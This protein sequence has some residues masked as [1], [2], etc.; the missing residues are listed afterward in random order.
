MDVLNR[1]RLTALFL[2]RLSRLVVQETLAATTEEQTMINRA[3][4]S[5]YR[6]CYTLGLAEEA[7]RILVERHAR[8]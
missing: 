7:K 3:I 8:L 5:T 1:G 6:D 2:S 4:L